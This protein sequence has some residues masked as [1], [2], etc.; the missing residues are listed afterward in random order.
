M[1]RGAG[2]NFICGH[3]LGRWAMSAEARRVELRRPPMRAGGGF[4][5]RHRH[6]RRLR[7]RRRARRGWGWLRFLWWR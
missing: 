2:A 7:R 1:P 5:W 6:R 3:P 4:R